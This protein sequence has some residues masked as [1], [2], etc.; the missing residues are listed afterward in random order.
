MSLA[1]RRLQQEMI[2]RKWLTADNLQ[3][4]SGKQHGCALP[5]LSS[6]PQRRLNA[7][8]RRA[9]GDVSENVVVGVCPYGTFSIDTENGPVGVA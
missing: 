8:I 5:G 9:G 2:A 3:E 7:D 4:R 1:I 6:H